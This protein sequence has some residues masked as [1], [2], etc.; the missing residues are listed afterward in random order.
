VVEVHHWRITY[1]D[2]NE[3][4]GDVIVDVLSE[5]EVNFRRAE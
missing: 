1:V 4:F 3:E 2:K 5:R